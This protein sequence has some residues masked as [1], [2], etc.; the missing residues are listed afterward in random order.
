MGKPA[1]RQTGRSTDKKQTDKVQYDTD[2]QTDAGRCR[3]TVRQMRQSRQK[4][5]RTEG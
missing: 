2:T 5:G 1:D 3:E 4:G